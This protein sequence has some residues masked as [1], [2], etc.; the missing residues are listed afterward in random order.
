MPRWT[1]DDRKPLG[2]LRAAAGLSR[3]EAAVQ[4]HI[5]HSTLQRYEDGTNDLPFSVAEQMAVLYQVPFEE[6][7]QAIR[8]TAE[9]H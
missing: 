6:I 2:K 5:G 1:N 9:L 8:E 7:R 4:M 3:N